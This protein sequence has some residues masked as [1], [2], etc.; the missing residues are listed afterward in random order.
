MR[1]TIGSAICAAAL[2]SACSSIE[3]P[4]ENIVASVYTLYRADGTADTL[5]TDT[6]T[7]TSLRGLRG[8]TTLLNRSV[9]THS[10]QLP[11]SYSQPEDTLF[12]TFADTAT[13]NHKVYHDTVYVAKTNAPHFESVDCN[14]SYFHEIT[15]IRH[16]RHRIDSIVINKPS[17]NYDL[18]TEHL[19]IYT[20]KP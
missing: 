20:S 19:R 6:L 4:V 8:D 9:D 16:T 13:S 18:T 15:G 17:V 14:I 1:K 2:L 3:C 7:I 12:L 11:M 10:F 5:R